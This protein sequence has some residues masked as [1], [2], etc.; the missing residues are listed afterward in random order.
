MADPASEP[1]IAGTSRHAA[2][3][4]RLATGAAVACAL[5]LISV[6]TW[7]YLRTESVALLSSLADSALDVL[8]SGLNFI[9]VR[10]ALAP[11]DDLHRFGHGKAEP[12]SGLAQSAFVASR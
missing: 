1:V 8:A 12:L 3:L 7:A 11:A 9:A 6:K 2:G 5:L 10:V 4:M